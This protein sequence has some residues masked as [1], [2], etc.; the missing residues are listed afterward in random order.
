MPIIWVTLIQADVSKTFGL[1]YKKKFLFAKYE[2]AASAH[3]ADFIKKRYLECTLI[4]WRLSTV[5]FIKPYRDPVH[6][7]T[8]LR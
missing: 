8:R 3:T 1:F 5:R 7:C 2:E 6:K 4:Q